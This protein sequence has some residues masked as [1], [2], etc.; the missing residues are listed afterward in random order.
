MGSLIDF[1]RDGSENSNLR[2]S[3]NNSVDCDQP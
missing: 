2:D 1:A 3:G